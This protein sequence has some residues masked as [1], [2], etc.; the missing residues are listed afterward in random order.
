MADTSPEA[1]T[2]SFSPT[3]CSCFDLFKS[4]NKSEV[5]TRLEA[6]SSCSWIIEHGEVMA[7]KAG[8]TWECPDWPLN[9]SRWGRRMKSG[10]RERFHVCLSQS[11]WLVVGTENNHTLFSWITR[12]NLHT[13]KWQLTLSPPSPSLMIKLSLP[14]LPLPLCHL[15]PPSLPPSES[16]LSSLLHLFG[17]EG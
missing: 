5:R 17:S 15:F 1:Q 2:V 11:G 13:G 4:L 14:I 9:A 16:S 8:C 3:L 6:V 7:R 12:R 10:L